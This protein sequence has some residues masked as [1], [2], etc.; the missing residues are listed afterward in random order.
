MARTCEVAALASNLVGP[1][2]VPELHLQP[3]PSLPTAARLINPSVCACLRAPPA[4]FD[5][6]PLDLSFALDG[7]TGGVATAA[8]ARRSS[9]HALLMIVIE[10]KGQCFLPLS[11][12]ISLH[13]WESGWTLRALI[14]PVSWA[15]AVSVV[16]QSLS[17]HGSPFPCEGLPASSRVGYNHAPA[18]AEAVHAAA[19]AGDMPALHAA[20]LDGGSTEEVDEVGWAKSIGWL[21]VY[22]DLP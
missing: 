11:V 7:F 2:E 17:I 19:K 20:L 4:V 14:R 15:D 10:S 13:R 21:R 5:D 16:V 8:V 22:C 3:S 6:H 9:E 1:L 12:P 18:P